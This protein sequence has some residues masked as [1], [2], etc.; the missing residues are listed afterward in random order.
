LRWAPA[1]SAECFSAPHLARARKQRLV[2]DIDGE[3]VEG[4]RLVLG[5]VDLQRIKQTV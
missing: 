4:R 2:A 3:D 5:A 1:A